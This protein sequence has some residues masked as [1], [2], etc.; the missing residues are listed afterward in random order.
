M[1]MEG[2][3]PEV[4]VNNFKEYRRRQQHRRRHYNKKGGADIGPTGPPE[5]GASCTNATSAIPPPNV[6]KG[7]EEKGEG[8]R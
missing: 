1:Y 2:I 5:Y 7:V 4:K 3:Q 8:A 6:G